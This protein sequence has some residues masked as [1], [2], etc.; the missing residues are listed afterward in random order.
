ML[1]RRPSSPASAATAARPPPGIAALTTAMDSARRDYQ[2]CRYAELARHLPLL[3]AELNAA[4]SAMDGDARRRVPGLSADACHVAAGLLLKLD[5]HGL[6]YLAADHSMRAARDSQDPITI[7]ASARIIVHVLTSAGH[8]PAA[9][10]AASTHAARPDHQVTDRTPESLSVYGSLLLA[11]RSPPPTTT[12]QATAFELAR[13]IDLNTITV[14]E[15]KASLLIDAACVFLQ[16]GRHEQ[17][18]KALRIAHDVARQ[19]V[20]ARPAV[21]QLILHLATSSPPS[22]RPHATHLARQAGVHL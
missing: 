1:P 22:V 6:A 5:D 3:L 11:A 2:M 18:C 15:R 14:T 21:R 12:R 8:L 17:A 10:T 16:W 20:A 19:E 9:V 7:A 13:R 4:S